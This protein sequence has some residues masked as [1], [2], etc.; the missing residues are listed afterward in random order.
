MLDEHFDR[1]ALDPRLAWL[2]EPAQWRL[3]PARGASRIAPAAPTDFWQKT[4]CGFAADRGDSS[5]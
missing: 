4:H 3:D 1:P 2:N 5:S